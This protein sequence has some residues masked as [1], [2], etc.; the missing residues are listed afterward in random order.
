M[1]RIRPLLTAGFGGAMSTLVDVTL[2]VLLVHGARLP[3]PLAAFM[4]AMGG[5]A[6]CFVANKYIA[7][8]DPSPIRAGQVARFGLVAV[9]SALLSAI[10]MQLVVVKLGVPVVPARLAV[11]VVVFLAWAYPAQRRLVWRTASAI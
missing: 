10:A 5:G 7:F 2:V 6:V 3:V 1:E 8:K 11:A 9:G 4:A